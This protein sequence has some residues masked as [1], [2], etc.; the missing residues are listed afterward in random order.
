MPRWHQRVPSLFFQQE[1]PCYAPITVRA[2]IL[3][4][5][6]TC[7]LS[8]ACCFG[9]TA[10]EERHEGNCKLSFCQIILGIGSIVALMMKNIPRSMRVSL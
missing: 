10:E 2:V 3:S 7:C 4:T 8:D 5:L 9:V 6:V 1:A